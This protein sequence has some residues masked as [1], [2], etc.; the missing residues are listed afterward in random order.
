MVEDIRA[1]FDRSPRSKA[2]RKKCKKGGGSRR[3][4]FLERDAAVLEELSW[5]EQ[6]EV[7]AAHPPE[8]STRLEHSKP[9]VFYPTQ[10]G[11]DVARLQRELDDEDHGVTKPSRCEKLAAAGANAFERGDMVAV[12]PIDATISQRQDT[13]RDA[14]NRKRARE[15]AVAAQ[16]C[17]YAFQNNT[18]DPLSDDERS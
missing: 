16:T 4:M 7:E 13:R 1:K 9:V 3:V 8:A 15:A 11:A 12:A 2:A 18:P 6:E 17:D 14:R 10:Y 5:R